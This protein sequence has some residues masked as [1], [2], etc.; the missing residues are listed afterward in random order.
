MLLIS[1]LTDRK[2]NL[3]FPK[4]L[5]GEHTY[6]RNKSEN[7]NKQEPFTWKNSR[8]DIHY[9][10]PVSYQSLS[11][12]TLKLQFTLRNFK[13]IRFLG[14]IKLTNFTLLWTWLL[15]FA[16]CTAPSSVT[17]LAVSQSTP[18]AAH[19]SQV[20]MCRAVARCQP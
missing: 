10:S 4:Q 9:R 15:H 3:S 5:G 2:K 13:E 12:T 14:A 7:G 1:T 16:A 8:Y 11:P 17:Q 6:S 19:G 18:A 20:Q